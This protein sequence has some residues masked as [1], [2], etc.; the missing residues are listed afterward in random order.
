M[1]KDLR[2]RMTARF[3]LREKKALATLVGD[4]EE[5]E[6]LAAQRM[7]ELSVPLN[8]YR[9][10]VSSRE[11]TASLQTCAMVWTLCDQLKFTR[12]LDTGSGF[13]S[14]VLR[15]A[16]RSAGLDSEVWSVDDDQ[17]WLT[18]T[19]EFCR[20]QGLV[21]DGRM[22]MWEKFVADGVGE[23]DLILHDLGNRYTRLDTLPIVLDRLSLRGI[24]IL[25]D[26]HKNNYRRKAVPLLESRGYDV[27]PLMNHTLDTLGRYAA[28][29][30]RRG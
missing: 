24:V 11:M 21:D 30:R 17:S 15:E 3:L 12:T 18:K 10:N 29:A 8:Y 9:Q 1:L 28:L 5:F 4:V 6:R 22:M 7:C 16:A 20:H 19:I 14:W 2:I 23:F 27:V 26:F 25:D 13:S